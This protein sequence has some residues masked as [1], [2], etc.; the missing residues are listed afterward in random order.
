MDS[1]GEAMNSVIGEEHVNLL[2][3]CS[4]DLE[5]VIRKIVESEEMRNKNLHQGDRA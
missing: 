4:T 1:K 5:D 2:T 3:M